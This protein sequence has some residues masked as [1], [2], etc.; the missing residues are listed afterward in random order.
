LRG[1]RPAAWLLGV[2]VLA[3]RWMLQ[4]ALRYRAREVERPVASSERRD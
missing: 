4:R 2:I 3:V 1:G